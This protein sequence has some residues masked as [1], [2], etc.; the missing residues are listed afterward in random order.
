MD[1]LVFIFMIQIIVVALFVWL[2]WDTRREARERERRNYEREL[3]LIAVSQTQATQLIAIASTLQ[4]IEQ[5][6]ASWS[7]T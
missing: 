3:Q 1:T 2:L 5:V 6:I 4:H 7:N